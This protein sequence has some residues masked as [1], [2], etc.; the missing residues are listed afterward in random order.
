MDHRD[1]SLWRDQHG[2]GAAGGMVAQTV[3]RHQK[4]ACRC[5][6]G[7]ALRHL[8]RSFRPLDGSRCRISGRFGELQC[9]DRPVI[10]PLV[11]QQF[12]WIARLYAVPECRFR[13]KLPSL[14]CG[15]KSV[16]KRR[17]IRPDGDSRR[18]DNF[19]IRA[20]SPADTVPFLFFA[21]SALISHRAARPLC[22]SHARC[23]YVSRQTQP[24]RS[25]D[26]HTAGS[27]GLAE[28]KL[29]RRRIC[30]P[31]ARR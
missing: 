26:G 7:R 16:G 15:Q 3:R 11:C 25:E 14:L 19:C 4:S 17:N 27:S 1:H 9:A 12:A 5:K 23:H 30:W 6:G 2:P 10:H 13:R 29:A 28:S 22:R 20:E 8:G 18:S 31:N 21:S 24:S